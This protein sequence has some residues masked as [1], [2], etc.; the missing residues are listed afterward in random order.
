M[1]ALCH[2]R[3][4][5]RPDCSRVRQR[6]FR[7]RALRGR[8]PGP[9]LRR[10]RPGAVRRRAA[11]T[12]RR[13]RDGRRTRSGPRAAADARADVRRGARVRR[14]KAARRPLRA[15]PLAASPARPRARVHLGARGR[16]ELGG[17][18]QVRGCRRQAAPS[19]RPV[20]RLLQFAGHLLVEARG[21]V[22]AMP[23]GDRD[24]P[25]DWSPRPGAAMDLA[26]VGSGRCPVHCLIRTSGWR[27]ARAPS[28]ISPVASAGPT[29]SGAIPT[30]SSA[31]QSRGTSPTGS[32]AAVS[33]SRCE[34]GGSESNLRRKLRSMR[35]DSG[36]GLASRTRRRAHPA[37]GRAAVRTALTGCHASLRRSGHR[38]A[39]PGARAPRRPAARVRRRLRVLRQVL[40]SIAS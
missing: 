14:W 18:L 30:R 22:G 4:R 13:C 3:F 10:V 39:R 27:V 20:G 23:H 11:A 40:M 21:R 9:A 34:S 36:P 28:S 37:S 26:A 38:H 17:A 25:R 33:R 7:P 15:P 6:T 8:P 32:A 19:L 29:A 5:E 12:V 1:R 24:R 16:A 2:E 35:H 31:R